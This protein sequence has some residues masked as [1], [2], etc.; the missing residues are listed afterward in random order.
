MNTLPQIASSIATDDYT[1]TM[2]GLLIGSIAGSVI[3]G[4]M[5]QAR[6][7]KAE[8]E[9]RLNPFKRTRR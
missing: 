1:V 4:Y 3:C 7:R 8:I 5:Q 9:R 6:A 2:L